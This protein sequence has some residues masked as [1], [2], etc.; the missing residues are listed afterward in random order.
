[1]CRCRQRRFSASPRSRVLFEVS[2]TI[3][4]YQRFDGAD[5]WDRDLVVGQDLQQEGLEFLV[6]LVDLVDQKDCA[7]RLL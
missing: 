2:R 7:A 3:G 6:R 5:L 4:A 1:M